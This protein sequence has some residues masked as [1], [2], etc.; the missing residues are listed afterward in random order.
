VLAKRKKISKKEMKEDKLVTYY[1]KAVELFKE[2]QSKIFIGFG[3][4]VV[5]VAAVVLIRQN[6]DKNNLKATTL[7]SKVI[8]LYEA[9]QYKEAIEG[10]KLENI[11]GLKKIADEYGS[12]NSGEMAKLYLANSYFYLG[13]FDNALKYYKDFSGDGDEFVAAGYAGIAACVETK[14]EFK[15][16]ADYYKKAAS[17]SKNN[18]LNGEY[19][20]KAGINYMAASQMN[21]AKEAF[22]KVKEDYKTSL[23]VSEADRYL[24]I[25]GG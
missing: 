11:A 22:Q 12:T 4:L 15:D 21:D 8:P 5:I 23:A 18:S 19:L 13:E 9:N 7:L 6:N 16:A 2:Y 17:V 3:I 14:K 24:T 25:I 20:L 10:K 1:Y